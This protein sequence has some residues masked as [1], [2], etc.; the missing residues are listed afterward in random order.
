MGRK[1]MRSQMRQI[2]FI[3]VSIIVMLLAF[4]RCS[5]AALDLELTQ[6]LAEAIPIAVVPFSGQDNVAKQENIA[7]IIHNDLAASGQFKVLAAKLLKQQPSQLKQVDYNTFAKL[8]V[9]D[10]VIGQVKSLGNGRYQVQFDLLD[11][12]QGLRRQQYPTAKPILASKKFTVNKAQLRSLAH[13]ISDMIYQQLTGVP[14]VFSTKIA[15]IAVTN[16]HTKKAR[17]RLIVSDYDG[18][19]PHVILTSNE[20][21][22][23]PAWSPN[24]KQLAYVSFEHQRAAI[25]IQDLATGHRQKVTSFPGIN[26]APAWSPD[27]KQ[28]ALVLSREGAPKIYLWNKG[29]HKLR[30]LTHGYAID[31][32]PAF[33][34]NGKSIIFTSNR[35]GGPQIYNLN[36]ASNEVSR[37]TFDGRYNATASY[38]P[39]GQDLVLLHLNGGKFNIAKQDLSSGALSVLTHENSDSS[40]KASPNGQMIIYANNDGNQSV[41]KMVSANGKIHLRLPAAEGSVQEPAWSP[42]LS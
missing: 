39:S 17:Y 21:I 36:L 14:G 10:I 29:N 32:E 15:Y 16:E 42:Y 7:Q 31:T 25:Y 11:V 13:H 37:V 30:Q 38:M 3:I 2:L 6:G 22:M 12:Y 20:P 9:S 24:G 19:Q 23:S 8:N 41:L 35:G 18:Y 27:G 4:N 40:P 34:P 28:L 1:D 26:G 5:H 33:A